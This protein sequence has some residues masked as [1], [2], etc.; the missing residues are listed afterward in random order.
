MSLL[1]RSISGSLIG[2]LS[3]GITI[4]QNIFIVPI[5]LNNWTKETYG[6]WLS[7]YFFINLLRTIDAGHQ[8]YIGNEFSSIFL[9]NTRKAKELL[10]SS[11]RIASFIGFFELV[12]FIVVV[13]FKIDLLVFGQLL[14]EQTKYGIF[15]M[16]VMWFMV[17]SVGG[18]LIRI[19]VPL[20][21]YVRSTI[22]GIVNKLIEIIVL[23]IAVLLNWSV[24]LTL[25]V[26][27]ISML[28]YSIIVIIDIKYLSKEYYPW[29]Q[30]GSFTAGFQNFKKSILV[31][32]NNFLEQFSTNGLIMVISNVLSVAW[33]P[34][35]STMRTV[36]N[37]FLQINQITLNPLSADMIRYHTN[38]EKDKIAH[39]INTNWFFLNVLLYIPIIILLPNLEYLF[40]IWT[41]NKLV[42]NSTF[43]NFLI[44]SIIIISYGK[45]VIS[46]MTNV[47]HTGALIFSNIFRFAIL[48]PLSIIVLKLSN[49]ITYLGICI[50][51]AEIF[52]SIFI[53]I[54]F[55]KS[56]IKAD[57]RIINWRIPLFM[58]LLMLI[59]ILFVH[60]LIVSTYLQIVFVASFL[61]L[62]LKNIKI[63]P[64]E[65]KSKFP[66]FIKVL[67]T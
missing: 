57:F 55:L 53:P 63:L 52:S 58:F 65:L 16:L 10:G 34:V 32:T 31:T 19:L 18:I 38:N 33:V 51:F 54:Y 8:I 3:F 48:I 29:W 21:F 62:I 36:S 37:S 27:S 42:F 61:A 12:I 9:T 46:Y 17:G 56:E 1:K 28:L 6:L 14:D 11:V 39:I 25:I 26:L 59:Y 44:L 35:F 4:I 67:H 15:L 40:K 22:W 5:I 13:Y 64:K 41:N 47:N 2:I 23:I 45:V 30:L 20:G 43:S 66:S 24:S 60:Y 49:S 7:C 50:C